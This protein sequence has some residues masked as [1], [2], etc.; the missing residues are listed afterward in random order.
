MGVQKYSFHSILLSSLQKMSLADWKLVQKLGDTG[1]SQVSLVQNSTTGEMAVLKRL[2][3][4]TNTPSEIQREITILKY[5]QPHCQPYFLCLIGTF[6]DATGVSIL[7]S[8]DAGYISLYDYI[9]E[10]H[11]SQSLGESTGIIDDLTAGLRELHALGV[12]HNDIKPL[13]ILTHPET[14]DTKYIDFGLSCLA[15]TCLLEDTIGTEPYLAPEI[16]IHRY[17][18]QPPARAFDELKSADIWSLGLVIFELLTGEWYWRAWFN[19]IF[20]PQWLQEHEGKYLPE[21]QQAYYMAWEIEQGPDYDPIDTQIQKLARDKNPEDI[22]IIPLL[23]QEIQN[24][25]WSVEML[26]G[27]LN[28]NPEFRHLP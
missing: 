16:F 13:N 14:E 25:P 17:D 3:F 20:W 28:P 12:A 1:V 11:G 15:S 27:M 2:N 4:E 19:K 24:Q 23:P 9:Q 21:D 22:P 5:I 26:Q 7:M 8:Y 6:E 10:N 18:F